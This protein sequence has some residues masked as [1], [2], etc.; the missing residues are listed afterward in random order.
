VS[1]AKPLDT[2][3]VTSQMIGG[4]L[5]C[6]LDRAIA[7]CRQRDELERALKALLACCD[8]DG[9]DCSCMDDAEIV[10]EKWGGK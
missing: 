3:A 2:E 4:Y 9:K 5:L 10:F 8:A 6:P 7:T 1:D